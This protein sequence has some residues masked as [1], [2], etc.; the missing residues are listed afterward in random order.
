VTANLGL[1]LAKMEKMLLIDGDLASGNL[2]PRF[3]LEY[4]SRPSR[5]IVGKGKSTKN[6]S[7]IIKQLNKETVVWKSFSQTL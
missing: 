1:E 2:A 6:W 7:R 5:H 4:N 3:G